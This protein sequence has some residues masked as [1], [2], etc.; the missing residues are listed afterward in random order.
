[1][2]GLKAHGWDFALSEEN[3]YIYIYIFFW[4]GGGGV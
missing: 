2:P 4:G 3:N 1:M